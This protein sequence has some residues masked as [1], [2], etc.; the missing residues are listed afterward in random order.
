MRAIA[1]GSKGSLRPYYAGFV[2]VQLRNTLFEA[3]KRGHTCL[4]SL[5][6]LLDSMKRG[7][8][9]PYFKASEIN[10]LFEKDVLKY[11]AAGRYFSHKPLNSYTDWGNLVNNIA[12]GATSNYAY[13]TTE[14]DAPVEERQ[15]ASTDMKKAVRRLKIIEDWIFHT[16]GVRDLIQ[17]IITG[18]EDAS[19]IWSSRLQREH[20]V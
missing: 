13:L 8:F 9:K 18:Q 4:D 7:S 5:K 16:P 15:E 6:I 17:Q 3:Y 12:T 19:A 11:Y 20:E 14:K 1:K 2:H 10:Q